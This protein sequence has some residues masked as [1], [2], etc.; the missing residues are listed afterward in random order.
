MLA[1][2]MGRSINNIQTYISDL[3]ETQDIIKERRKMF[4]G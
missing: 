3:T 2:M 4:E 1:K